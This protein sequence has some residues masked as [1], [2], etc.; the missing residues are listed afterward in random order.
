MDQLLLRRAQQGDTAAFEQLVTPFEGIIWRV[1]WHYTGNEQDARD[2]AQDTML[3]AW[4]SLKDYR[5]DCAFE[6]WLY[7][8]AASCSLDL[9]RKEKRRPKESADELAEKGFD[10]AD[11]APGTEETAIKNDE[12]ARLREA[13][14]RLPEDQRDAL[15]LTQLEGRP[16]EETAELLN[17][18][19]GTV[20]SR[21]NRAKQKLK[22]IL[23]EP[24]LSAAGRVI[25]NER[26]LRRH[27]E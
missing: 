1:C 3:K 27:E 20:K 7:R 21:V 22:E 26:R 18:T 19:P 2:C 10:P 13:I 11:P 17:T 12:H 4:R 15:V 23:A 14:S 25:Q 8:I 9:L 16:Y 24:E 5:G 6:S